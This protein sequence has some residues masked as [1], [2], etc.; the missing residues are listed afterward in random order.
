MKFYNDQPQK[1]TRSNDVLE[2]AELHYEMVFNVPKTVKTIGYEAFSYQD[3]LKEINLPEG[4]TEIDQFA[5]SHCGLRKICIP[6]SVNAIDSHAFS[7]CDA[8]KS[9]KF[10]PASSL[11][12]ISFGMFNECCS[13][14]SVNIPDAVKSI[15][16]CA[17]SSCKNLEKVTFGEKSLLTH[18]G[19]RAFFDA[20]ALFDI[21]LPDTVESIGE[22]AFTGS[23]YFEDLANRERG[24]LYIGKALIKA[25]PTIEGSYT[26]KEGTVCIADEAFKNCKALSALTLPDSVKNVGNHAFSGCDALQTVSIGKGSLL[27]NIGAEAFSECS[28]LKEIS[29]PSGLKTIGEKAFYFCSALPMPELSADTTVGKDAFLRACAFGAIFDEKFNVPFAEISANEKV[30]YHHVPDGAENSISTRQNGSFLLSPCKEEEWN[31]LIA[32]CNKWVMDHTAAEDFDPPEECGFAEA[33]YTSNTT[34]YNLYPRNC[35]VKNGNVIGFYLPEFDT[36][37]IFD[38]IMLHHSSK[39]V[40]DYTTEIEEL[41]IY[42]RPTETET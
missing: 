7:R 39:F 11:A 8:L 12:T 32:A 13:L 2:K 23:A 36:Y 27:K 17:F 6:A 5:F 40:G 16:G 3:Y 31:A 29:L 33:N 14:V 4:V 10:A 22:D 19:R 42:P 35:L 25:D 1:G 37:F 21:T 24:V 15:E 41:A 30:C 34:R 26:V 18:I 28:L 9:V 20:K 38:K